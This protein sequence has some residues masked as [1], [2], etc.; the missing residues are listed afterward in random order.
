MAC[1]CDVA[2]HL[3][4]VAE[5]ELNLLYIVTNDSVVEIRNLLNVSAACTSSCCV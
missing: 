4:F 1:C 5:F 2:F 3:C